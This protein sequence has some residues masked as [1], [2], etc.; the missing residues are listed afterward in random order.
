MMMMEA[1]LRGKS[2]DSCS[3][4]GTTQ[5]VPHTV[6]PGK[7]AYAI[8]RTR[9]FQQPPLAKEQ[10]PQKGLAVNEVSL[11]LPLF[12]GSSRAQGDARAAG[13]CS[14]VRPSSHVTS[15]RL[16]QRHSLVMPPLRAA[17]TAHCLPVKPTNGR[18]RPTSR[19]QRHPLAAAANG[20]SRH[21]HMITC[22]GCPAYPSKR[23]KQRRP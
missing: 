5:P 8:L 7:H 11:L 10:R 4:T 23:A 15:E 17:C 22:R 6:G 14:T 9:V 3:V 13:P 12:A 20:N 21:Q 1:C 2:G 18:R 19:L 16:R